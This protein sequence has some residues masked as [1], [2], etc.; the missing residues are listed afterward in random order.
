MRKLSRLV[1]YKI[2]EIRLLESSVYNEDDFIRIERLINKESHYAKSMER[3]RSLD[4]Y[5]NAMRQYYE[6]LEMIFLAG[7]EKM[8]ND[9]SSL[10]LAREIQEKLSTQSRKIGG[11]DHI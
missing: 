3:K 9:L 4:S 5:E 7:F 6:L 11:G 10:I 2:K 1:S 8:K